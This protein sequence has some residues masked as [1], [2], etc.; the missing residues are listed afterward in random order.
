MYHNDVND[1][2]P[3]GDKYGITHQQMMKKLADLDIQYWFGYIKREE[4]DKMI[5]IFSESLQSLSKHRL[6]I[7]QFAATDLSQLRDAIHKSITASI[8]GAEAQRIALGN[9]STAP[10]NWAIISEKRGIKTA[11]P[12]PKT[13][14][15]LQAGL[16]LDNPSV[17]FHIKIAPTPFC[18]GEESLIYRGYDSRSNRHYVLKQFKADDRKKLECYMKILEIQTIASTYACDFSNNKK[19][20][21]HLEPV[22]LISVDIADISGDLY[23]LQPFTDGKFEKYNTNHGIVCMTSPQSDMMQ[24]FSHF[25]YVHSGESLLICDLEGARNGRGI[26]LTDPA[27]HCRLRPNKFGYPDLGFVG[28]KRFFR[29]H[30]CNSVCRSMGL[31]TVR[32]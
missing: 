26:Q 17:P 30:E 29:S 7:R 22:E 9:V 15:H 21:S 16:H 18:E 19:R 14:E 27:I 24:A 5:D 4:T 12:G 6:I 28:I 3:D 1:N 23:V 32:I 11:P 20:P 25:T 10:I 8:F 31:E 13:L 2:N